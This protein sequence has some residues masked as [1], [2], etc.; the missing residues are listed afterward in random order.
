MFAITN[1][2]AIVSALHLFFAVPFIERGIVW[3]VIKRRRGPHG[4]RSQSIDS[5]LLQDL[6]KVNRQL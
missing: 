3:S 1:D 2:F 6:R 4:F 5:L